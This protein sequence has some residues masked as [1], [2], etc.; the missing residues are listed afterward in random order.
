MVIQNYGQLKCLPINKNDIQYKVFEVLSA[1]I[2]NKS[3][4]Y[5]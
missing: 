5:Q 4:A 2:W 1:L 3:V